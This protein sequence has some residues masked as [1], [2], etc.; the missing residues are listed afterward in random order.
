MEKDLG[1]PV[2]VVNR[3]GAGSQI[4][5]AELA[6]SKPD[7]Y[8]LGVGVL[9]SA[10]TTYLEP[11][12]KATYTRRSF[13]PIGNLYFIPSMVVVQAGSPFKAMKDLVDA[14]KANPGKIKFGTSGLGSVN[15]IALAWLE[16][17]ARASFA[18]VH[19]DGATPAI[20]ALLGGHI[21]VAFVTMDIVPRQGPAVRGLG[22]ADRVPSE[23]LPEVKTLESQGYGVVINSVGAV[24]A[25]AGLPREAADALVGAMKKGMESEDL[26]K[27]LKE[28]T[29]AGRYMDPQEFASYW[30][31]MEADI[32]PLMG[33]LK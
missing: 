8:T 23:Y 21:D 17:D 2:Q 6:A 24:L 5:L 20:T 9:P 33:L 10:I 14:A 28:L 11:E 4:G 12:R 16:T 29:L 7:G 19:F 32:T 13:Q 15:H 30:A 31:R 3:P 1:T 18:A 25:P 22:V 26:K 27:K